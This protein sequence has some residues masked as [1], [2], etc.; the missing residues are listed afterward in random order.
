VEG[1]GR[2]LQHRRHLLSVGIKKS[3]AERLWDATSVGHLAGISRSPRRGGDRIVYPSTVNAFGNTNGELVDEDYR[4]DD[5]RR[6]PCPSTIET[7]YAPQRWPRTGWP[8]RT[9]IREGPGKAG[10]R[11]PN[12]HS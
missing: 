9:Q 2:R 8:R 3:E 10:L 12:D 1:A 4:R 6:L 11:G 5:V 7:K